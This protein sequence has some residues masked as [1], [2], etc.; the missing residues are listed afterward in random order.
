M[1]IYKVDL[2]EI[3]IRSIYTRA[4][5][6]KKA[7]EKILNGDNEANLI[8][9]NFNYDRINTSTKDNWLVEKVEKKD[10]PSKLK[11]FW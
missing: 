2:E 5:S 9:D 11:Q 1:A 4:S 6:E 3:W 10:L 8:A 7:L